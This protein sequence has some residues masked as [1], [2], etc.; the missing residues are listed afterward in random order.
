[1]VIVTGTVHARADAYA[2]LLALCREHVT[3][4]RAEPGCLEHGVAVDADDAMRLV[5]F[6]RWADRTAIDTHM[7]VPASREF[8]KRLMAL[9]DRPPTLN[10]YD[11]NELMRPAP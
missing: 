8:G 9:V 6:E 11:V 10:L 7:K 1:M 4:S 3:R 2:E 5:F